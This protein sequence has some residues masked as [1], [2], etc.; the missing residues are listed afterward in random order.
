MPSVE[1]LICIGDPLQLRPTVNNYGAYYPRNPTGINLRVSALS[2]DSHSGR[3]LYRFD[4]SLIERLSQAGM[5]MSQLN[6]QR[7]MRPTIS[8]LIR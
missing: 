2:V 3:K 5:A 7:R 8:D 6:V 1:H 4:M